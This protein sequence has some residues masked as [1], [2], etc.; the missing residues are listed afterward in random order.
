MKDQLRLTLTWFELSYLYL[1]RTLAQTEVLLYHLWQTR[2][3]IL[4]I[5]QHTF[6]QKKDDFLTP[7][8]ISEDCDSLS[9]RTR[10]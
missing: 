10:N 6:I 8:W 3:E 4:I 7:V 5:P 2:V 9:C 1:Y